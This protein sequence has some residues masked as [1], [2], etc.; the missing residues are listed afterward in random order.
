MAH[1]VSKTSFHV[2]WNKQRICYK[3]RY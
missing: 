3:N 2:I 1:F